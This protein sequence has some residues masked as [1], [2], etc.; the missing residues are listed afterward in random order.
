MKRLLRHPWLI[1]LIILMAVVGAGFYII[2]DNTK[3]NH[4]AIEKNCILLNNLVIKSSSPSGRSQVL[5]NEIIKLAKDNGDKTFLSGFQ[6][7]PANSD[8][9]KFIIDCKKVAN[10]PEQIHQE[11]LGH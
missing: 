10:H 6:T 9:I 3:K 1:G 5:I 2:T 7:A 11:Q 4:L 8:V